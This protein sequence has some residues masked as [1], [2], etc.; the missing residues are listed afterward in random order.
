MAESH[1]KAPPGAAAP[2]LQRAS[3]PAAVSRNVSHF[4]GILL[5]A[6][7]LILLG[8]ALNG[9]PGVIEGVAKWLA[10]GIALLAGWALIHSCRTR[11]WMAVILALALAAVAIGL[12][13][14]QM[15]RYQIAEVMTLP[16]REYTNAEYPE[17]P[18]NRSPHHGKYQG[19][20]VRLVRK[21]ATH[22]DVIVEP[23][24]PAAAKDVATITFRNV[25]VS[26]MT[27]SLPEWC[28]RDSGNTRIALTDRQW[29][30]QQVSFALDGR[31]VEV[32]GG[33]GF[34]KD[35]LSSAELAKNCL[36]AGLWEV[37][38]FHSGS[39]GKELYYQGWFTFPLGLYR[40][41]FERGTGLRYA[42]HWYYLEH[43]FD[44]AG[45]VVKLDDLRRVSST[46]DAKFEFDPGEMIIAGGEQLRKRRTLIA[47]N[48]RT[49][50]DFTAASDVTFASFIPPGRYSVGHP[51]KNEYHR[52]TAL[53]SVALREI[54]SPADAA[55]SDAK[56]RH[57]LELLFA[58]RNGSISRFFVSGFRWDELPQLA[59]ADYAKGLYMPMGIGVPPFFQ[60]EE[61][62]LA[63][64]PQKSAYFS[65]LLD[66]HD[67]WIDH[68]KA[69]IDGPVLHRDAIDPDS[70]HLYL[71]SYERHSL[72]MHLIV[73]R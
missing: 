36:N 28:R 29:N 58:D 52:L 72:V 4:I 2:A 63:S 8:A 61:A 30:R 34:E 33:D 42:D 22:F 54:E 7:C 35:N 65:V 12:T 11:Q 47:P 50:G 15:T 51:W 27:P 41:Q 64:P 39:N 20:R 18:A 6:G 1:L 71:L 60:A 10:G 59:V 3:V 26:L 21:D 24:S 57:E 23:A 14:R 44:P 45:T 16:L 19:R 46:A 66:P 68:H 53:R 5:G 32:T 40:E 67:R 37:L 69:A 17:D 13:V 49:W 62:L 38:L 55:A 70:L 31:R 43:W 56:P 73:R 9:F 48:V 25:D